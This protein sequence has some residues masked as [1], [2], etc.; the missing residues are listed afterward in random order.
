[1]KPSQVSQPHSHCVPA[2]SVTHRALFT[3][4]SISS[5]R[6]QAPRHSNS[7]FSPT[8][9]T[10]NPTEK[11]QTL[12][13]RLSLGCVPVWEM[14]ADYEMSKSMKGSPGSGCGNGRQGRIPGQPESAAGRGRSEADAGE[15]PSQPA[16]RTWVLAGGSKV[17]I[18]PH[19]ETCL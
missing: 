1:M 19:A 6:T 17:S 3:C 4:V 9:D 16:E 7:A 15:S 12:F 13:V 5:A 8:P 10:L 2:F 18:P 11:C 14:P